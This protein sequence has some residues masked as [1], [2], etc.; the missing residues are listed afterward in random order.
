M[1]IPFVINMLMLLMGAGAASISY[2]ATPAQPPLS[3]AAFVYGVAYDLSCSG[4]TC[5]S[6]VVK[7]YGGTK[8]TL[9]P[10]IYPGI[11]GINNITTN[12]N[13]DTNNCDSKTLANADIAYALRNSQSTCVSGTMAT[14]TYK[15]WMV[16]SQG[17]STAQVLPIISLNAGAIQQLES[18]TPPTSADYDGFAKSFAQLLYQDPNISGVVFDVEGITDNGKVQLS[19]LL[20]SIAS[21]L[22]SQ[23]PNDTPIKRIV[24]FT[25]KMSQY[26]NPSQPGNWN[27]WPAVNATGGYWIASTYDLY[28]YDP[29]YTPY[30]SNLSNYRADMLKVTRAYLQSA[31]NFGG[32]VQMAI[33][34]SGSDQDSINYHSDKATVPAA[35]YG[36]PNGWQQADTPTSC[37]GNSTATCEQYQQIVLPDSSNQSSN[38]GATATA[39]AAQW[40]YACLAIRGTEANLDDLGQTPEHSSLTPHQGIALNQAPLLKS[41]VCNFD[42]SGVTDPVYVTAPQNSEEMNFAGFALYKLAPP[43]YQP[44]FDSRGLIDEPQTIPNQ[45][46]QYYSGSTS[47]LP[48]YEYNTSTQQ[49]QLQIKN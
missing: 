8:N 49:Y 7:N 36:N 9:V 21:A 25:G 32:R 30:N 47:I 20:N 3:N 44:K 33:A 11:G 5:Q 4:N 34:A 6:Q 19:K 26:P 15:K 23:A 12:P 45:E 39:P 43:N 48:A 41:N 10:T 29:P 27:F 46:W 40:Q 38:N 2:A 28:N 18:P 37:S 35:V 13:V 17:N 24:I 22:T 1:K 42:Q 31:Y 14:A 16:D